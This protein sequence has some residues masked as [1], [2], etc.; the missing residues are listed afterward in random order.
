MAIVGL[1]ADLITYLQRH[2]LHASAPS[3]AV[4]AFASHRLHASHFAEFAPVFG[5]KTSDMNMMMLRFSARP[6]MHRRVRLDRQ[7]ADRVDYV[8]CGRRR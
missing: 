3:S 5:G 1:T 7:A 6:R 4:A 8:V 2:L